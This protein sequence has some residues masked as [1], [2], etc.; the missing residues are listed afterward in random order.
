M[1]NAIHQSSDEG[2]RIDL[3]TTCP[4]PEP[5]AVGLENWHVPD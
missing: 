2:R 5:L 3:T 1:I 4:Q